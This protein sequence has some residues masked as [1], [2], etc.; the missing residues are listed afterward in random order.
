MGHVC[1]VEQLSLS[2]LPTPTGCTVNNVSNTDCSTHST[3]IT[4]RHSFGAI[5]GYGSRGD[6]GGP[7]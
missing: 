3:R 2:Q 6:V 5:N 7:H 4:S 1:L